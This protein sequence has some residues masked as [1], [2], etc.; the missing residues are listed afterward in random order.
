MSV[1]GTNLPVTND[2]ITG[3]YGLSCQYRS[4]TRCRYLWE[5]WRHIRW[6]FDAHLQNDFQQP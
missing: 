6:P 4:P 5:S 2:D 1:V 3:E